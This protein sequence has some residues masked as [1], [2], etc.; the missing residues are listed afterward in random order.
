MYYF[1]LWFKCTDGAQLA[2]SHL[3]PLMQL[4]SDGPRVGAILKVQLMDVS[5]HIHASTEIGEMA[6]D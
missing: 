5:S 1:L 6:G 3:G 2:S 4:Q